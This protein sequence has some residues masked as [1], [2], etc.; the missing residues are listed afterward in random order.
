MLVDGAKRYSESPAKGTLSA[1][2]ADAGPLVRVGTV[3]LKVLVR[4]VLTVGF[5][6]TTS[7]PGVDLFGVS[8]ASYE[9]RRPPGKEWRP[10]SGGRSA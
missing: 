1:A 10:R 9:R 3:E 8:Q 2:D 6:A 7:T 5:R 4:Q